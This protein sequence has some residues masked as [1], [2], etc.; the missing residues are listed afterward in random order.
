MIINIR[1]KKK[2]IKKKE[3]KRNIVLN[4]KFTLL[5]CLIIT[6]CLSQKL[7][8][9]SAPSTHVGRVVVGKAIAE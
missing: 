8:N 3:K 6:R 9:V 7:F 5:L 4:V 2:L 1:R